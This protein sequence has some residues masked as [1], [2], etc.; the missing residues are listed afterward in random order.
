MCR[1][2]V[3][4]SPKLLSIVPDSFKS[5]NICLSALKKDVSVT[6]YIPEDKR[7]EM[8][9]NNIEIDLIKKL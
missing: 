3:E 6:D 1:V 9:D 8:F 4:T 5:K 7:Y 2:A